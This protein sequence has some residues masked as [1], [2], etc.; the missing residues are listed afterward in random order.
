MNGK[1]IYNQNTLYIASKENAYLLQQK[2]GSILQ[3]MIFIK[4]IQ[5]VINCYSPQPLSEPCL[6]SSVISAN[7]FAE[8]ASKRCAHCYQLM[9]STEKI[10][11]AC[12]QRLHVIS[13]LSPVVVENFENQ[14]LKCGLGLSQRS[15]NLLGS[16]ISCLS[17]N[18][19]NN[20]KNVC[21]T[22]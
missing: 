19:K 6:S 2:Q 4:C 14:I 9:S 15:Y 16:Q 18:P 3:N 11:K 20:R 5:C 13:Q 1:E 22:E 12:N 7:N 8:K 10:Q 21:F 17:N